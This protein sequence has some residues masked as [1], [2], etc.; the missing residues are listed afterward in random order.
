MLSFARAVLVMVSVNSSR[1]GTRTYFCLLVLSLMANHLQ[2]KY[3]Q[4]LIN[5]TAFTHTSSLLTIVSNLTTSP[6]VLLFSIPVGQ[7]SNSFPPTEWSRSV[8]SLH[9]HPLAVEGNTVFPL[10][11]L[12]SVTKTEGQPDLG[13]GAWEAILGQ[14]C[15]G[16]KGVGRPNSLSRSSFTVSLNGT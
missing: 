4:F 1:A 9:T 12:F 13:K 8:V 10:L 2:A 7:L 15:L 16:L 11:F 5:L 6:T 14:T 3:L